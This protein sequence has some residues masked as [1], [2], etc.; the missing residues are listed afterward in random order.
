[1]AASRPS[2]P[3]SAPPCSSDGLY[4]QPRHLL[5]AASRLASF[6]CSARHCQRPLPHLELAVTAISGCN[7]HLRCHRAP[8]ASILAILGLLRRLSPRRC[9]AQLARE[10]T[11]AEFLLASFHLSLPFDLAFSQACPHCFGP[12]SSPFLFRPCS[13]IATLCN[14]L[15][16]LYIA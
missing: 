8:P 9:F 4:P 2:P 11:M 1:M 5:V 13:A 3:L 10:I 16:S 15:F 6:P 14:S 7:K 12:Y